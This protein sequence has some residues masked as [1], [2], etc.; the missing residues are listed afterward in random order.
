MWKLFDDKEY[1]IPFR[2]WM[3]DEC[4]YI[5][6]REGKFEDPPEKCPRC[7]KIHKVSEENNS[8]E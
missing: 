2:Y 6:V 5:L 7:G 4:K 1:P 8:N 3:C